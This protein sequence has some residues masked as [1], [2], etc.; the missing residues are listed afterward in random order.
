MVLKKLQFLDWSYTDVAFIQ[1]MRQVVVSCPGCG[2]PCDRAGLLQGGRGDSGVQPALLSPILA[3]PQPYQED[4]FAM[5]IHFHYTTKD[6]L[7][8]G[9]VLGIV[10]KFTDYLH[11]FLSQKVTPNCW[12]FLMTNGNVLLLRRHI[13][14][15]KHLIWTFK[16][17]VTLT[18]KKKIIAFPNKLMPQSTLKTDVFITIMWLF[19]WNLCVTYTNYHIPLQRL[20]ANFLK[21]LY[22]GL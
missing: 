19:C 15:N 7:L 13:Q 6:L 1:F 17:Q 5:Y 14:R 18:L 10:I 20:G 22:W 2:V 3:F 4:S 9:K 12:S 21:K 8:W 11:I 16:L